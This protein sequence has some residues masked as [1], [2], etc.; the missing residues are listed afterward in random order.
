V[1]NATTDGAHPKGTSN[2][3]QDAVWARFTAMVN[4]CIP[5]AQD[6]AQIYNNVLFKVTALDGRGTAPM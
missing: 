2:V 6:Q 1:P 5:T 4:T 3:S